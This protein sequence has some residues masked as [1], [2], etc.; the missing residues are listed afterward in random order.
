[1]NYIA[2]IILAFFTLFSCGNSKNMSDISKQPSKNLN[3]TYTID[4][5]GNLKNDIDALS[6][7]FNDDAKTVTGFSGCNHFNG[8]YEIDGNTIKIGP[9]ASTRKFCQ[10]I[11]N[12]TESKMLLALNTVNSFKIEEGIL[13]LKNDDTNV[14]TLKKSSSEMVI[15]YEAT[16]RGFFER[17]W[18]SKETISFSN[19]RSLT[20][21]TS[22]PT[23]ESDWKELT[24]LFSDFNVESLSELEAP[25]KTFQHDAAAMAKLIVTMEGSTYKTSIFDHGN[26]P[27]SIEDI[28]N[29]VLSMKKMVEK[30]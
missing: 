11:E 4:R 16:T 12:T 29:K 17:I 26:P 25:S 23:P 15:T 1:M 9:L 5:I 24:G 18:V 10:G 6:I 2:I 22:M 3:N 19:D 8:T 30:K 21:K 20:E 28:V 27:K 13:T 14:I 7:T